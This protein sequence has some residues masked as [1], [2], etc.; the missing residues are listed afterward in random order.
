M[1]RCVICG[2]GPFCEIPHG[3][4]DGAL[5]IA[6]D[7]GYTALCAQGIMPDVLVG[8]FDSLGSMPQGIEIIGYPA[9]KDDTDT[10]LAVNLA[11][12][13]GCGEILLFGAAGGRTDH[14]LANIQLLTALSRRGISAVMYGAE[15]SFF[16]VTDGSLT[17]SAE[18]GATVSVFCMG[19]TASGVTL[20]GMKYPLDRATLTCEYPIGVSNI[21]LG[22]NA[23]V[24]VKKGTL[25]V[26]VRKSE[27][28]TG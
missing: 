28:A 15:E 11:L 18:E 20:T 24:S 8:D 9:E 25:L 19:E 5:V 3:L 27:R 26:I 7:G 6:A 13:R 23:C 1:K 22:E 4:A 10:G 2:A 12:E 17:V 16:A 21:T 14:T